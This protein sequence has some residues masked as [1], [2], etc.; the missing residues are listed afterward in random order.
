MLRKGMILCKIDTMRDLIMDA[1]GALIVSVI[2]YLHMVHRKDEESAFWHLHS[3]FIDAN[4]EI[5]DKEP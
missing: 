1:I 4:P 2:G 5:F 3:E